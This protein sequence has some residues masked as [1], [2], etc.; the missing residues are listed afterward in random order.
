VELENEGGY[1][2]YAVDLKQDG[3]EI[4]VLVDAGT[5]DI[6]RVE[7]EDGDDEEVGEDDDDE[8]GEDEEDEEE[9]GEARAV[10]PQAVAS[11]FQRTYPNAQIL[12][13][14]AERKGGE[15]FFEIDT[16]GQL[17]DVDDQEDE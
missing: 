16:A 10:L 6:L 8:D 11:A 5:G 7:D 1:L 9:E 15:S 13:T 2:V 3:E 17:I 4:E 12:A 14:K